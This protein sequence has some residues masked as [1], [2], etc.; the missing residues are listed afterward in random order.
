VRRSLALGRLAELERLDVD[1]DQVTEMIHRIAERYG[2]NA[3]KVEEQLSST[4]GRRSIKLDLLTSQVV[5][6]LISICKGENPL[7]PTLE[8][9]TQAAEDQP[10]VSEPVAASS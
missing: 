9:P 4:Q 2:E 1:E 6:R 3:D 10:P 5:A 8:E 7:L